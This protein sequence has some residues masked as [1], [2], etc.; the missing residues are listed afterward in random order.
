MQGT[1]LYHSSHFCSLIEIYLLNVPRKFAL[2]IC[3][4]VQIK[5]SFSLRLLC[6]IKDLVFSILYN[7]ENKVILVV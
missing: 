6:G 4:A 7:R 1:V 5:Y 3:N 2:N